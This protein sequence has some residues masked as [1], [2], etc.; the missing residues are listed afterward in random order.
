M[1]PKEFKKTEKVEVWKPRN[2]TEEESLIV[3]PKIESQKSFIGKENRKE[4]LV[5]QG[6]YSIRMFY[7]SGISIGDTIFD[8]A[9][10]RVSIAGAQSGAIMPLP[11]NGAT[12]NVN[13]A[14]IFSTSTS[15][16]GALDITDFLNGKGG[17]IIHILGANN[18]NKTT[19]K[20][21]G[22]LHL[23]GD[24]VENTDKTLTLIYNGSAWIE[25]SRT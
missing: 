6:I 13:F 5:G 7:K 12:P 19:I 2:I 14:N 4:L 15:N 3:I 16:T 23:A 8:A 9:P 24:W 1:K 18:T 10:W 21:A 25:L 17:Q 20:D 22:N 11:V